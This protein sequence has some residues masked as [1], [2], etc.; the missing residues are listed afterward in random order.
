MSF[1]N[2][3]S[4]IILVHAALSYLCTL[5]VLLQSYRCMYE[6]TADSKLY[7]TYFLK[8][9]ARNLPLSI[10]RFFS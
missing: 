4:F 1:E 2:P 9:M 7:D 3:L 6:R 10:T 8:A 5:V